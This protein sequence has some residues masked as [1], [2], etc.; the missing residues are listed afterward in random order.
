VPTFCLTNDKTMGAYEMR[1]YHG[2]KGD[3]ICCIPLGFNAIHLQT[4]NV[5][6]NYLHEVVQVNESYVSNGSQPAR[7]AGTGRGL[8]R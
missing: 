3:P 5:Q 7:Y 1:Y 8:M 6:D 4:V 2:D